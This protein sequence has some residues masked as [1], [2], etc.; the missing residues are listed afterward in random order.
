M[1]VHGIP[2]SDVLLLCYPVLC[3]ETCVWFFLKESCTRSLETKSTS[4]PLTSLRFSGYCSVAAEPRLSDSH[5][6]ER[7]KEIWASGFF[8]FC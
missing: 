5:L 7:N 8:G 2:G 3:P 6:E 4:G 1:P